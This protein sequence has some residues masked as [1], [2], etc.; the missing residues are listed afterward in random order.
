MNRAMC[1]IT[2]EEAGQKIVSGQRIFITGNCSTPIPFVEALVA[3]YR[4]L[5]NIE[6]VQVLSI[7]M[8]EYITPEMSEHIRVNNLFISANMRNAV[9]AGT[10]DF[11]PIFLHEIP[12]L[13][14][15]GHLTPDI[16]VIHVSP[17]DEHG[18]CSYGTEVGV[19]KSA[20]ESARIVIAQ[21]NPYMPR[22]LGDS[23]IHMSK[24]D[25]CIEVDYELPEVRP[26]PPSAV[27][28]Q[29]AAHIAG[30]IPDGATLQTGIGGIPDAVLRCLTDHRDL[31]IHTELFSDGVM[32]MIEAG[33]I[34]NAAKSIHTGKVVAGFAIGSR[35][36]FRYIHDNP[37]IELHPTEYVND[38]FIIARN[39][40]MVSINS[41]LEIDLTGQV[42]AD[43]IGTHFYSGVGGQVDF[44][45]GAAHSKD[46]KS[47]IALPSTAKDGALS[48]I[49]PTLK[50]GAGV[51]TSRNDVHI[52]AT[53]FGTADLFGKTIAQR[54][55]ALINI[56]H[57]DFREELAA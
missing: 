10:A 50:P 54:A 31:G 11:T 52:I 40:R 9:N 8:P 32:E 51:T 41:A 13:F 44:V 27:Q 25:Y 21:I 37:V 5:E 42:C 16:A 35:D 55:Q 6:V 29:V 24:I 33:V 45:R 43:S 17:P 12:H 57:P 20:A 56:A 26:L 18:Y 2:A 30:L 34:T 19:T 36:L 38:P 15:R 22:T 1:R 7:G 14:R 46:G 47:I 4:E 28:D 39:D 53:E 49:V 48:R 3:R 23:F